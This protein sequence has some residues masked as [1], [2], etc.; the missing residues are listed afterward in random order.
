[1]SAPDS[2]M[3]PSY[4][5]AVRPPPLVGDGARLS[6]QTVFPLCL[7]EGEGEDGRACSSAWASLT[8]AL[9]QWARG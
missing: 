4:H 3:L 7:G 6:V 8:P 5:L 2:S 9:S 1:M